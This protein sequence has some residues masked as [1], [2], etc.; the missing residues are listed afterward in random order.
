LAPRG[1]FNRPLLLAIARTLGAGAAM[2]AVAAALSRFPHIVAAPLAVLSYAA[3]LWMLGGLD[4]SQIA[5][6][7]GA[8]SRKRPA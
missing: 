4:Q 8:L 3:S 1:L 5:L 6:L 7:R 2:A